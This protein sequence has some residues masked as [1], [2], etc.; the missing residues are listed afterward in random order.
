M[1]AATKLKTK[2]H[3]VGMISAIIGIL[4][5][6][7]FLTALFPTIYNMATNTTVFT[8]TTGTI[9]AIV[10]TVLGIGALL[11]LLRMTGVWGGK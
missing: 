8:G 2:I 6:L 10:P 9:M 4:V 3:G 5:I 1:N 7:L 11:V